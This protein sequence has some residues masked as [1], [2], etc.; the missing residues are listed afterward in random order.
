M[1]EAYDPNEDPREQEF[2]CEVCG[3]HETLPINVAHTQGWDYPPFIGV[4]GVISPRTCPDCPMDKTLWWALVGEHK[5]PVDLTNEQ[6]VTMNRIMNE[7]R[8]K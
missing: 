8:I 6:I 5:R 7:T 1:P 4:Y 3:R 2:L